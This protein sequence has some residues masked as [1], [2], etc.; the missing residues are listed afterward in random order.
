MKNNSFFKLKGTV[1]FREKILLPQENI[2]SK[3]YNITY[4]MTKLYK[5]MC[6]KNKC[7]VFFN[8]I[9]RHK[10]FTCRIRKQNIFVN[11][12]NYEIFILSFFHNIIIVLN[13]FFSM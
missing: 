2:S 7:F 13:K 4:F 11:L 5:A 12:C 8:A 3:N 10:V 1:S 9:P 6:K